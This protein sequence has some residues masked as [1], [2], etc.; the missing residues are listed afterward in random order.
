[1]NPDP[2]WYPDPRDPTRSRWWDG[3]S[4]TGHL[5][6]GDPGDQAPAPALSLA[7]SGPRMPGPDDPPAPNP[8]PHGPRGLISSGRL[9][10]APP[11]RP[12][13]TLSALLLPSAIVA[14][15]FVVLFTLIAQA[16]DH[17]NDQDEATTRPPVVPTQL[18]DAV[19]RTGQLG[20]GH[21]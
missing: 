21:R 1:M 15:V 7:P 4:W 11:A 8:R 2:G 10:G 5:H 13:R 9:A 18:D 3:S 20:G 19:P 12:V 17:Q 6:D 16:V 14:A